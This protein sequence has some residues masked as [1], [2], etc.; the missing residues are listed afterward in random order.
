[1]FNKDVTTTATKGLYVVYLF[2]EDMSAFYLS[3]NQGYTFF[4][5]KFGAGEGKS[6]I[7]LMSKIFIPELF[8]T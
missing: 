7:N 1:L 3:L 2:C 6:K 8:I 5:N 4:K